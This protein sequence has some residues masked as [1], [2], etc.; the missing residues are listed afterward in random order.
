MDN[1]TRF[2]DV[3]LPLPVQRYF[4]YAVPPE[5]DDEVWPGKRVV[6]QFGKSRIYTALIHAVHEQ[7]PVDYATKTVKSVI[8]AWPV[9]NT[10]QMAFWEWMASYYMTTPG[11]VMNA[12]LPSA[13]KLSSESKVV[14]NALFD[15]DISSLNEKE[16]LIALALQNQPELT[17]TDVAKIV[18]QGK[19]IPLI[20]TLTE[21]QVIS[22]REDLV[23]TYRPQVEICT[24]LSEKYHD[25]DSLH[26]IMDEL[27]KRAHKQLELLLSF[28]HLTSQAKPKVDE[29]RRSELLK[30]VK[31]SNVQLDALVKK[32]VF[33]LVERQTSRIEASEALMTAGSIVL[34]AHQQQAFESIHDVLKEKEVALLHGITSSGKTEI[35][36]KLIQEYLAAGKQVLY[37][38]PEIALTTQII[39]R[40]RKYFGNRIGVYHSRYNENERVEIWQAVIRNGLKQPS[41]QTYQVILGARSAL[42]LPFDNLGLVIVDEEHDT[43]YKQQDPAPRYHARDA[44]LY[45]ARLHDAKTVLGSAT[46][47]LESYYHAKSGRYGLIEMTERYGGIQLPE[48]KV[49]DIKAEGR[50]HQMK[51]IFSQILLDQVEQALAGHEQAILFQ[52]RRGFSLRIECDTCNWVP[53]C[54]NC[55]VTL[56]YHKKSNH[57]RCHYCGYTMRVPDRCPLCKN[58]RLRMQGFGTEKV[59]EELAVFFPG[60]AIT[61]MDLDTTHTR[62][63]HQKIISELEQGRID[64]LVGTQMVT[65]GLDFDNVSVV[66]ILNADNMIT[67]PDFRSFERSFQMMAQVSGRSGR[68]KKRGTVII[69]TSNPA[70]PVIKD[71]VENDYLAMYEQEIIQRQK[72]RYPPFFRLV[73]LKLQHRDPRVLN[74]AAA[75]LAGQLRQRFPKRIL[76]P[77]YPLISR[78]KNLYIKQ[79]LVKI[80]RKI[81]ASAMKN[82]MKKIIEKFQCAR[83][84]KSVRIIV[85]VDPV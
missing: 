41:S 4:T 1:V 66:S 8:D 85:N 54:K 77:E 84:Y 39:N 57:L 81:S 83:E 56:I 71:V 17:M 22:V 26:A 12:S 5:L 43:S 45:L 37:L 16:Y 46:P 24:R 28:I 64:I 35:Y 11:E 32:G 38:L 79:I 19:V 33:E 7:P 18:G 55:D 65:K 73:L 80:D 53:Q 44:A 72:F 2:V 51:S 78:V 74:D 34:T 3:I 50:K 69:Q 14:I 47:S 30:S 25:S 9:V 63:A 52:N 61:R 62:Y 20:K 27:E 48:I 13:L 70:H 10:L 29:L 42:F 21:K 67:F 68:K 76:G 60:A 59:E 6:V 49:V 75:V 82:E 40:L 36:I 15:G 31:A 23:D 58:T